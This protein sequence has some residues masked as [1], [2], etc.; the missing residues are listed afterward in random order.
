MP[1]SSEATGK[2]IL[3]GSERGEKRGEL[4]GGVEDGDAAGRVFVQRRV[5]HH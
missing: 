4:P 5:W 1:G 3:R 2:V